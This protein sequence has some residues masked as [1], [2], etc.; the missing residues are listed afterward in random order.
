[1][2]ISTDLSISPYF[3]DFDEDKRFHQ[4]LFKPSVAV[5]NRELA[6]VQRIFQNQIER[7]GNNLFKS[8][9]II[10]GVNFNFHDNYP[11]IKINDIQI[12]NTLTIPAN[13]VGLF[14]Q[15]QNGLTARVL[16]YQDGFESSDPDLKT[17]YLQYTNSGNSFS[18]TAFSAGQILTAIDGNTAIHNVVINASGSGYSNTDSVVFTPV[19][20]ANITSGSFSVGDPITDIATGANGT[21]VSVTNETVQT[22]L[23]QLPGSLSVTTSSANITGV[24]TSFLSNFSNGTSVAIYSNATAYTISRINVVSNNTFMNLTSNV[25]FSNAAANYSN[26]TSSRIYIKYT[27]SPSA[28]SNT[29]ANASNW[30]FS[31]SSIIKGISNTNLANIVGIVG[32]NATAGIITD[33]AGRIIEVD[34]S[35]GGSGYSQIPY[36]TMQS[37]AGASGNLVAQNFYGQITVASTVG[38]IGTGYAF[39]VTEGIVY[40]K[41]YFIKVEPQLIIISKYSSTPDN[42]TVG[43]STDEAI[44]NSNIDTSLL[45]NSA[46]YPNDTAPGADR[47]QLT[48][49]LF[50]TTIAAAAANV[51]FFDLVEWSAGYPYKQ[52]SKTFYN[53]LNDES[54][55]TISDISG[56]FVT[57]R[58][59]TTTTSMSNSALESNNYT[60]VVDPGT[61]YIDG[62]KLQTL[63]NFVTTVPKSTATK[64]AVNTKVSLNYGN[65]LRLNNVGGFF[66][67][68]RAN[69][70]DLYDTP[71][72]LLNDT[73]LINTANLSPVGTKIGS[74]RIRS[75]VLEQGTP[76]TN[77]AIYR[78][79]LFNVSMLS[80]KNFQSVRSA[81]ANSTA[82]KG[83]ADVVLDYNATLAANVAALQISQDNNLLFNS[84]FGS[85]LGSNTIDYVYRTIDDGQNIA[86]TGILQI[87]LTGSPTKIFPYTGTLSDTQKLDLYITPLA[88]LYAQNTL[89]GTINVISTS[90]VVTGN[91]TDFIG[92]LKTGQYININAGSSNNTIRRVTAITNSSYMTVDANVSFAQTTSTFRLSW[93]AQVPIPLAYN[94]S[95]NANVDVTGQI[96]TV[97]LGATLNVASNTAIIVGYNVEN[98]NTTPSTKTPNRNM[99]VTLA[100]SNNAANTVGP[101]SLGIPDIFR[102]RAVFKANTATVN[103]AST[104]VTSE[105]FIDHNQRANYYDLG[106]L[107]KNTGSNLVLTQDDFLLVQFDCFT[108]TP[109]LF[110]IGSYVSSNSATRFSVDSQPLANLTSSVNT[111][112]IP[113]LY[114]S[115]GVYFDLINQIDFRPYADAQANVTSVL[116]NITTNPAN[117][118]SFAST[119]RYFPLPDSI[120]R[121]TT[122]YFLG[123][124]DTVFLDKSRNIKIVNGTSDVTTPPLIPTGSMRLNNI[125]VPAYPAIP[126]RISANVVQIAATGAHNL[127]LASNYR[128]TNRII[129]PLFTSQQFDLEQPQVYTNVD[130][131]SIDRRLKAV[132]YYVSFSLLQSAI[133]GKTIASSIS[134]TINRFKYGFLVDDYKDY[135]LT[136]RN[137]PEYTA[138]VLDGYALPKLIS[139]NTTHTG[140]T[141]QNYTSVLIISQNSATVANTSANTVTPPLYGAT[142]TITPP[143]FKTQSFTVLTNS[144]HSPS[145]ISPA[146]SSGGGGG[147]IVCTAMNETYGFGSFRNAIWVEHS[148]T[149]APEYEIG[150]HKLFLPIVDFVYHSDKINTKTAR[151]IRKVG[152]R[153]ARKRTAD[154]WKNKR[155][156]FDLEGRIYRMILEPICYIAG[157]IERKK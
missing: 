12:D 38:S 89:S 95:M 92:Q 21:I 104:N 107:V 139:F 75:L 59:L 136:N 61:A 110:T 44:I 72:F 54:A 91:G 143:Q 25:S 142:I 49:T 42:V 50:K 106:N 103:T 43:F 81:Y 76:G 131:G 157:L 108:T 2:P 58:F 125:F 69:V 134:P 29:S 9:T 101:W 126:S 63:S 83:I 27:P 37:S 35:N 132:E 114:T 74:A 82:N 141:T 41:G 4:V 64:V 120:Y 88:S 7:L 153:V 121:Q 68:D 18:D 17:L 150:Y 28:L 147:K 62:Y 24:G 40:Q 97:S 32:Q 46:G 30:T 20:L 112:E 128:L 79:Y 135:T 60:V 57:D 16:N 84:G 1:L 155:G 96:L 154:I 94:S 105:F 152:E 66:E 13:Y 52:N 102:L 65:Y 111:V 144:S 113:E 8:G 123:R 146:S 19:L 122:E 118:L 140:N 87:T 53:I 15:N 148:K 67:F 51:A 119:D 45:D 156:R 86:N 47:L 85:P 80:G 36:V 116:A 151:L 99:L 22:A 34:V 138:M 10:D 23:V 133:A 127:S 26:T 71:K 11:F 129:N 73:S 6:S 78:A 14:L 56:N 48:A 93:P 77:S 115:E 109:G 124:I 70:I 3:D 100:L 98:S 145:T 5:Q 117:T 137:S 31:T 90:N 39:S 55:S 149:M 33:A 130:I